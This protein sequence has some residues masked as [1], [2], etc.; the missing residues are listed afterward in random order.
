MPKCFHVV[1]LPS[2]HEHNEKLPLVCKIL[3]SFLYV[4]GQH[5]A[6]LL[7]ERL[8]C[9]DDGLQLEESALAVL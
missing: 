9:T 1:E 2:C 8:Q 3:V 4:S 7:S 6:M 5:C